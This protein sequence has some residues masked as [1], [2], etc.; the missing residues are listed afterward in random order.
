[1]R[2]ILSIFIVATLVTQMSDALADD[3]GIAKDVLQ[4]FEACQA[5]GYILEQG[6]RR[7]LE[8]M[9][10]EEARV[11]SDRLAYSD[12]K[13]SE[14]LEAVYERPLE[15]FS[16]ETVSED[17]RSFAEACWSDVYRHLETYRHQPVYRSFMDYR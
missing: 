1:M 2:I 10:Q 5:E 9:T 4:A 12:Y 16:L 17:R 7:R 8:G 13:A 3:A 6:I 14:I 15:S 11:H